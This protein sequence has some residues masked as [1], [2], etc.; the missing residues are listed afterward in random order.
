MMLMNMKEGAKPNY[1]DVYFLDFSG[2]I[3]GLD[4]D[5]WNE[6]DYNSIEGAYIARIAEVFG[7]YLLEDGLCGVYKCKFPLFD[8]TAYTET[9]EVYMVRHSNNGETNF[10]SHSKAALEWISKMNEY[11]HPTI[12]SFNEKSITFKHDKKR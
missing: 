12:Y 4:E 6:V 2:I 9:A 3:D 8:A 11:N 1:H 10:I 7:R 5:T